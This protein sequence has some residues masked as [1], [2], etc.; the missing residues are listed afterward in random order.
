VLLRLRL[1]CALEVVVVVVTS[2]RL[3]GLNMR[4]MFRPGIADSRRIGELVG[5]V[6]AGVARR[7]S[8]LLL[9]LMG[10]L[11][12][13]VIRRVMD[14]GGLVAVLKRLVS[15]QAGCACSASDSGVTAVV[16]FGLLLLLLLTRENLILLH[17][18]LDG[19]HVLVVDGGSES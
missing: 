10:L 3:L 6:R 18:A 16:M 5:F 14:L 12:Q 13:G 15:A 8:E 2:V 17:V 9:L 11:Q 7:S 1:V 4:R 19:V